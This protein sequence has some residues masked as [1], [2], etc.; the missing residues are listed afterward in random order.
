MI[1]LELIHP[2]ED[3]TVYNIFLIY[4]P[5]TKT[6]ILVDNAKSAIASL[7]IPNFSPD[8]IV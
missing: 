1:T 2:L 5:R 3:Q 6:E 7:N 4:K 8:S